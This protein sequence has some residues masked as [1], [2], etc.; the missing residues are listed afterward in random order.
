MENQTINVTFCYW[1]RTD[2]EN[3][4]VNYICDLK[5]CQNSGKLCDGCLARNGYD[6]ELTVKNMNKENRN[7]YH[8]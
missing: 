3:S 7:E 8:S 2:F 1:C 6:Y 4:S 5:P